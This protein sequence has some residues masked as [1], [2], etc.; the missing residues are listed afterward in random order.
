MP[1]NVRESAPIME[2]VDE[3]PVRLTFRLQSRR[4]ALATL[5]PGLVLAGLSVAG[6]LDVPAAPAQVLALAGASGA[7]LLY[8]S[9][10]RWTAVQW[11]VA[12]G[13][14]RV[15]RYHQHNFHGLVDWEKPGSDFEAIRVWRR[16]WATHWA[17]TLRDRA[18]NGLQL[19]KNTFGA[20]SHEDA[21]I[22]AGKVSARTGVP[23]HDELDPR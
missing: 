14:R 13:G 11:L 12:D 9:V 17:I 8:S 6:R 2:L 21:I 18:G 5:I 16:R 23:I 20:F 10:Y 22:L 19:G 15:I 7:V 4:W 3:T 1:L